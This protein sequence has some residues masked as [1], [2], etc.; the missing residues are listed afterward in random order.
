[1]TE[2]DESEAVGRLY[3]RRLRTFTR[4]WRVSNISAEVDNQI[5]LRG[6]RM[7]GEIESVVGLD[8]AGVRQAGGYAYRLKGA[9]EAFAYI[10]LAG[11]AGPGLAGR[12]T[13]ALMPLQAT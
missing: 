8:A 9:T 3:R 4:Q 7:T 11:R 10:V 13:A 12:R 5:K 1:V 2:L 6:Q